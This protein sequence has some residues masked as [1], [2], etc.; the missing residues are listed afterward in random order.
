[1]NCKS[2]LAKSAQGEDSQNLSS[3]DNFQSMVCLLNGNLYEC[4]HPCDFHSMCDKL[5]STNM[6][7][8]RLVTRMCVPGSL[9]TCDCLTYS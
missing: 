6:E 1:V 3:T 2:F 7:T 5:K 8:Y 9:V 4:T